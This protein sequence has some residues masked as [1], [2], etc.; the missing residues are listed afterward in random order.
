[1]KKIFAAALAVLT[2]LSSLLIF[3]SCGDDRYSSLEK[4]DTPYKGTKLY[5]YNWGEYFSDGQDG[6]YDLEKVFEA[7][8]GI[9]LVYSTYSSN[10]ELYAKLNSGTVAYDVVIP[11]DY[12]IAR[13][14]D[15]GLVQK[16]NYNNIP[17]YANI[18]DTYKRDL[19]FDMG[20]DGGT[21][22]YS[23]PYAVGMI[24]VVYNKEYV[25]EKDAAEQSWSLLWNE[26]YSGKIL[27]FNN[28]RDAFGV[29]MFCKGL[30]VNSTDVK[31]WNEAYEALMAQK[32]LLK[33][34]VM[35]EV[36]D[37]MEGEN[38]YVATYYAGDCITMMQNNENLAFYYPKEGTNLFVDC[39]CI[40]KNAQN[41]GAAELFINF[42]L[43]ERWAIENALYICYASP[44]DKVVNSDRYRE[45]LG[46][47][48]LPILYDI[49]EQYLNA[50]GTY[51]TSV[52]QYYKNLDPSTKAILSN[53]WD[54]VK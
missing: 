10:E 30:D 19:Y 6:S 17:N 21:P 11:S 28:S 39:M 20:G 16:L 33:G 27:N 50:D 23:V 36:F 44:N 43:E 52:A 51:N 26:S 8:Y 18:S 7:I 22:E 34:L 48:Y 1:M 9:D 42:M 41:V 54:K 4:I 45:E 12:M 49:P 31:V 3:A 53:L 5:V 14:I 40:P 38:S 47:E 13:L 29:A 32:P 15:E 35:D 37:E 46:E 2:A 25:D 24:G